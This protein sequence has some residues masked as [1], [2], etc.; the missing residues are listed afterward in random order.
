V[1]KASELLFTRSILKCKK[2]KKE[3][4]KNKRNKKFTTFQCK[5]EKFFQHVACHKSLVQPFFKK[6]KKIIKINPWY[7]G[8][9]WVGGDGFFLIYGCW[10]Y[11]VQSMNYYY[12]CAYK[13]P[14]IYSHKVH[15][16]TLKNISNYY[17]CTFKSPNISHTRLHPTPQFH[18]IIM[19]GPLKSSLSYGY[20]H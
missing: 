11:F 16:R 8:R 7:G 2:R 6:T 20:S 15:P 12:V 19:Y 18:N 9:V 14:N 1:C 4:R 13:S 3:K 5:K 10:T 17:V